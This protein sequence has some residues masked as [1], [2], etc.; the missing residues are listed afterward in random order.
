MSNITLS[1]LTKL[2]NKAVAEQL[3]NA[4]TMNFVIDEAKPKKAKKSKKATPKTR[5]ELPE[6]WQNVDGMKDLR[7]K[8]Y[9]AARDEGL[10]YKQANE[11]GLNAVKQALA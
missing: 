3:G 8:H 6:G 11:A 7:R 9:K 4:N 10:S 1:Q 2:I 5:I